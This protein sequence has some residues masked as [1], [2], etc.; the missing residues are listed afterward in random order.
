MMS[1]GTPTDLALSDVLSADSI[2]QLGG[3]QEIPL[4]GTCGESGCVDK[5]I[6]EL[7]EDDEPED[8]THYNDERDDQRDEWDGGPDNIKDERI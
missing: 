5:Q 8:L 4:I 2:E 7:V 3:V 6:G 1:C